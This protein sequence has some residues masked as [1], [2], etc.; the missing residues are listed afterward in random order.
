M[1]AGAAGGP[2]AQA[3]FADR[4]DQP[5]PGRADARVRGAAFRLFRHGRLCRGPAGLP[6]KARAA[7]RGPVTMGALPLEG[8]R[9]I[10]ASQV[11]AGPYCCLLLGDMGADV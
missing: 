11:M 4:L 2:L 3:D 1:R 10:D 5:Q 7:L 8:L 9:V 6:R